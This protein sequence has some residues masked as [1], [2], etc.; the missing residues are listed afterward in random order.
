MTLAPA[1]VRPARRVGTVR[2][3]LEQ[4]IPQVAHLHETVFRPAGGESAQLE[5]YHAYF[6]RVFLHNPSRQLSLPSLVH[7]EPDG[8]ITGF[9]GV[10]PRRMTMNGQRFQ[11]AISSQFIVDR[12][13]CVAVVAVRLAKAF[14]DGP[15]DISLTDEATDVS[16][17]I[18]EGLGGTTSVVRSLYWTRPLRPAR[19][20]VSLARVRRGLAPVAAMAS[21]MAAVADAVATRVLP[22]RVFRWAPQGSAGDLSGDT[23]LKHL[24][25]FA[26]AASLRMDYDS[27]TVH[28][29][30]ERAKHRKA[31]QLQTAIVTT[32]QRMV[33]W[34]MYHLGRDRIANVLHLAGTD[35]S[36]QRVLDHLFQ[37]A[38]RHGAL[39][40]AGRLEPRFL[41]ALS[42]NYC[43]FHRRGP[44]V[45]VNAKKPELARCFQT[46]AAFFSRLDGEWC[47]GF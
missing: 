18:W 41:Q 8:R 3:F 28:W 22:A 26:G 24:P 47:L 2:P 25:E 44:W 13:S 46:E 27:R 33:G 9:L 38:H 32:E 31:G 1:L 42:D 30:F 37:D 17:G 43:L 6:T 21:P 36:I 16:R 20:I 29:L 23:F 39:A 12:S 40:V 10:V 14:L 35:S 7:Q 34:F 5:A 45:L 4:D 19:L 11:A 15:Q